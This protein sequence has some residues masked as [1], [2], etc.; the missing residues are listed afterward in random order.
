MAAPAGARHEPAHHNDCDNRAETGLGR[1]EAEDRA[2]QDRDAGS[3]IARTAGGGVQTEE[4]HAE[5][6]DP[7]KHATDHDVVGP[8]SPAEHAHAD[9]H[10]GGGGKESEAS[11]K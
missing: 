9:S 6:E 2:E 3:A 4:Q 5:T 8:P 1:A 10:C 7:G 11:V